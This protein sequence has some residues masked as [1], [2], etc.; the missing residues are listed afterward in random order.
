MGCRHATYIRLNTGPH[1]IS[2]CRGSRR[3][4]THVP[5]VSDRSAS[6]Q[7][8]TRC[9]YGCEQTATDTTVTSF[10]RLLTLLRRQISHQNHTTQTRRV[11]GSFCA[12]FFTTATA[13]RR[14]VQAAVGDGACTQPDI[15]IHKQHPRARLCQPL[16]C[17]AAAAHHTAAGATTMQ[18]RGHPRT[19]HALLPHSPGCH[20]HAF[21]PSRLGAVGPVISKRHVFPIGP[22]QPRLSRAGPSSIS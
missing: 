2:R 9:K 5:S 1:S 7:C 14:L 20:R 10:P 21:C 3:R 16:V 19:T 17:A 8:C 6:R 18:Y 15:S 22:S 11:A 4:R 13:S 12:H